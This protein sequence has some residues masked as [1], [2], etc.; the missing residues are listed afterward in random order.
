MCQ[1]ECTFCDWCKLAGLLHV[2]PTLQPQ[3]SSDDINDDFA[4]PGLA[5]GT[6]K[7]LK[8][9]GFASMCPVQRH[10]VPPLL[11]DQD[12]LGAAKTGSGKTL[13]FLIPT[14]EAG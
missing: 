14:I 9:V 5:E 2:I 10:T 1:P 11:A 8:Y 7:A 3:M 6:Q 4:A 13:A 12:V